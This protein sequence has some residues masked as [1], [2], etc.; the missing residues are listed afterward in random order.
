MLKWKGFM[1]GLFSGL[2]SMSLATLLSLSRSEASLVPPKKTAENGRT[3]TAIAIAIDQHLSEMAVA[4][5]RDPNFDSDIEHL[6]QLE[7][8]YQES[9]PELSHFRGRS[10]VASPIQRILKQSYRKSGSTH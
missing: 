9:L 4:K 5:E 8:R 10:R 6:R 7:G 2:I 3:A 1:S